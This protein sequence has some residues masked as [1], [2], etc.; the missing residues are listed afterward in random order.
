MWSQQMSRVVTAAVTALALLLPCAPLEA[1]M[2]LAPDADGYQM[3]DSDERFGPEYRFTDISEA[4]EPEDVGERLDIR[5]DSSVER[6]LGF[7]FVFY[8]EKYY[9]IFISDNGYIAFLSSDNH[10]NP[11]ALPIPQ[12]ATAAGWQ[13]PPF[14]APWFDDFDPDAGGAIYFKVK[15]DGPNR[16]AIVQWDVAHHDAPTEKFK[17]QAV[18]YQ[19]S[20]RVL[21]YYI[22]TDSANSALSGGKSATV[23]IQGDASIGI[24]YSAGQALLRNGLAVGFVP[25]KYGHVGIPNEPQAQSAAPGSVLTYQVEV[26]NGKV[27]ESGTVSGE[28]IYKPVAAEYR[29]EFLSVPNW[30]VEVTPSV[31]E[32]LKLGPGE[33]TTLTIKVTLPSAGAAALADEIISFKVTDKVATATTGS[34]ATG[35]STTTQ[36]NEQTTGATSDTV[37]EI[38]SAF[39]L[40]VSCSP[41]PCYQPDSDNDGVVDGSEAAGSSNDASRVEGFAIPIGTRIKLESDKELTE[42]K[43]KFHGVTAEALEVGPDRRKFAE[44]VLTARIV[45]KRVAEAATLTITPATPWPAEMVLYTVNG[46]GK[47]TK[48]EDKLWRPTGATEA[49]TKAITS[50]A[51][52]TLT[53]VDGGNFDEDG[54]SNGVIVTRL[55]MGVTELPETGGSGGSGG[56]G[57]SGALFGELLLLALGGLRFARWRGRRGH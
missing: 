50:Y 14:V 7:E 9:G 57:G 53:V 4:G 1:R 36:N 32:V 38:A 48:A 20:N 27:V 19:G 41:T 24:N 28:K 21:F 16:R 5:D 46:A 6:R 22:K 44:G 2:M 40:K 3:I 17:F 52:L 15:G 54:I 49:E 12:V 26:V 18:L 56:N 45:P 43:A 42:G 10:Y 51:S 33:S 8:G 25:V 29:V 13:S 55:A 23:G 35:S 34:G 11:N 37:K 31:T 30:K 39:N 47:F